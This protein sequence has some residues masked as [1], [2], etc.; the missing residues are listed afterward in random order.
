VC[1]NADTLLQ[2]GNLLAADPDTLAHA[3]EALSHHRVFDRM[4]LRPPSP[5][6]PGIGDR[7]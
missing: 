7:I 4:S 2:H 6:P 1:G 5:A 3:G